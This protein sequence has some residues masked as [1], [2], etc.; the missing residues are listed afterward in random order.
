MG[1]SLGF[2]ISPPT[3]DETTLLVTV[4]SPG[5]IP[6]TPYQTCIDYSVDS[7]SGNFSAVGIPFALGLLVIDRAP[8]LYFS[9]LVPHT[10]TINGLNPVEIVPNSSNC[11]RYLFVSTDRGHGSCSIS[12]C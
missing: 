8:P 7:A 3:E 5:I 4:A 6:G 10:A 1:T 2:I 11:Q 9:F 12:S